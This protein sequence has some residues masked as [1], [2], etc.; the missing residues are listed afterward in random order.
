M[1]LYEYQA[2]KIFSKFGL[3]VFKNWV[4][5]DLSVMDSC[6][7]DISIDPPWIAKCQI[8][9]GGRG[10]AGGI[11][12]IFSKIELVNFLKKWM[13]KPLITSQTSI[14]GEIVNSILI[15]PLVKILHELYLSILI[16]RDLAQIVFMVSAKGGVNVES[17]IYESP[18]LLYKKNIDPTSITI[19]PYEGRIIARQ[20]GLTGVQINKFS[21]VYVNTIRM[22][23]EA[24]LM[25]V[26]INPLVVTNDNDLVCLDSKIIID[27]NALFRQSK[28]SD[29]YLNLPNQ[30]NSSFCSDKLN[31]NYVRL[32]GNIGCMVNGA[33]LAMA[34]MDLIKSLG[35]HPANFLDIGGDT[36]SDSI[37]SALKM[38][39][40]DTQ[41]Q[42]IFVNI[43]GGIVCCDLVACSIIT[44]VSECTT[45]I[46][47]V[48]RLEGNNAELGSN[49]L[50]NS[51]L[52]IIVINNLAHAIQKVIMLVK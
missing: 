33:G 22:F 10:K 28:L 36:N 23:F 9:A 45:S 47:I 29:L 19:N 11:Q 6:V 14:T 12:P 1:N 38:L 16:D 50:I 34:T 15:E 20:L 26:E 32:D 7:T 13:G 27:D 51:H 46:P 49:K 35:G 2:K 21:S 52:N 8:C 3:P 31:I 5:S 41:V 18:D 40:Q 42:A 25:L 30:V 39:L 4:C 37:I 48:V 43:F 24:D 17:L 44:A